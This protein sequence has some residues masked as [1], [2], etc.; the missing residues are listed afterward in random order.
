MATQ[1]NIR[2]IGDLAEYARLRECCAG[3]LDARALR[4]ALASARADAGSGDEAVALWYIPVL[5]VT[6]LGLLT[7]DI[8]VIW[9]LL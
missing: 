9:S 2:S 8:L 7:V 3:R 1:I 6:L 4:S 5:A